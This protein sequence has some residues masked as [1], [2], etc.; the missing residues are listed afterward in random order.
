MQSAGV[1]TSL[2]PNGSKVAGAHPVTAAG[3]RVDILTVLLDRLLL[4]DASVTL[5]CADTYVER[6]AATTGSAAE[7]RAQQKVRK[8]ALHLSLI[9]I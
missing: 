4:S 3:A 7:E 1:P 8:Y 5:C 2:E 9:H 6:A